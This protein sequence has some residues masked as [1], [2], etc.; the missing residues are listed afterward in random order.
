V[1][2]R[3][4]ADAGVPARFAKALISGGWRAATRCDDADVEALLRSVNSRTAILNSLLKDRSH[5]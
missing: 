4:L 5:G 3:L 2:E 1:L